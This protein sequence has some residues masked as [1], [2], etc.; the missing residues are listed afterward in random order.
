MAT[1]KDLVIL[2]MEAEPGIILLPLALLNLL[3]TK[4]L[5]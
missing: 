5:L 2:L 1:T 4:R 3:E